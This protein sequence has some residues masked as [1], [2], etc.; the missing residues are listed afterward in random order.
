MPRLSAFAALTARAWGFGTG[1]KYTIIQTFTATSTWTCPTGVTEVDYLVVAGGGGSPAG[2]S[3][4]ASGGSGAGGFRT[5]T[6]YAVVAGTDYTITVGSG[7]AAGGNNGN[8]SSWN[9]TAVGS[10][11]TIESAG[12]GNSW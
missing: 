3:T 6:G 8:A 12:G 9:T 7:G 11:L 5:G 4:S 2:S 10:G 1:I